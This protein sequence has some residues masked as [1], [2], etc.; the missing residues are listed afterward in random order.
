VSRIIFLTN[1]CPPGN[2]SRYHVKLVLLDVS[3]QLVTGC[4]L[5]TR[6]TSRRGQSDWVFARFLFLGLQASPG[7]WMWWR[8]M[9]WLRTCSDFSL[10]HYMAFGNWDKKVECLNCFEHIYAISR[11][12]IAHTSPYASDAWTY[13]GE[14]IESV[15]VIRR[16]KKSVAFVG[17]KCWFDSGQTIF[18][19]ASMHVLLPRLRGW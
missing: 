2:L 19:Q 15:G 5:N 17:G 16:N 13:M 4:V 7:M 11:G 6:I 12:W 3:G 9:E 10:L 14:R 1:L 18:V 8:K